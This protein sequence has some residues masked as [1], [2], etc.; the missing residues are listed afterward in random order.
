M[1]RLYQT[2]RFWRI[3]P[4]PRPIGHHAQV[5]GFAEC[6]VP[7]EVFIMGHSPMVQVIVQTDSRRRLFTSDGSRPGGERERFGGFTVI[8]QSRVG[9]MIR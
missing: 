5:D 3:S 9:M 8:H 1:I 6:E 7:L 2:F 4:W